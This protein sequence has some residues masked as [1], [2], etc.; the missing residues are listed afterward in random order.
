MAPLHIFTADAM[1]MIHTRTIDFRKLDYPV[2]EAFGEY[3]Q[4]VR[5]AAVGLLSSTE[6]IE[7]TTRK[8]GSN[9]FDIP[10]PTFREL[11]KEH[12]VAPFFVF[13]VFCVGLW[14]MDEYW[15]YSL[16]TVS[17]LRCWFDV[18]SCRHCSHMLRS[19]IHSSSCCS[20][21]SQPSCISAFAV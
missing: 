13:Q 12:A 18:S 16:F 17:M 8:Y 20:F 7:A 5:N 4:R 15:Y 1:L 21:S 11:F 19:L 3:K 2:H 6:Q 14:L 10:M 9:R